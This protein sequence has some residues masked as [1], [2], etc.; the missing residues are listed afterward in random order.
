MYKEVPGKEL[1]VFPTDDDIPRDAL[2][3]KIDETFVP[4]A[5]VALP[6]KGEFAEWKKGRILELR[7]RCFRSLP[8][9]NPK[10]RDPATITV[11]ETGTGRMTIVTEFGDDQTPPVVRI[12]DRHIPTDKTG[13]I[14]FKYLVSPAGEIFAPWTSK[15]P[16]NYVQRSHALLGQTVDEGKVWDVISTVRVLEK[17]G[18][19]RGTTI[20]GENRD[21]ILAAYAALFEP[22]IKEV[23][24]VNP[25]KSHKDGPHFLGVLRVVDIP[26]ALGLLAPTPLTIIGGNDPAFDRTEEIY[27]LAGGA[28]KLKR[29]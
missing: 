5:K 14:R 7:T 8:A 10:P 26:E 23:I 4:R 21:G 1:R 28:D 3:A 11:L 16:P 22:S 19:L 29:K 27:R 15:S 13:G 9:G 25:P 17:T 12:L 2:N 24:V 18:S 6:V 20:V